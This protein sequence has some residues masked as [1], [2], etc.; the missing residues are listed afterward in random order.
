MPDRNPTAAYVSVSYIFFVIYTFLFFEG[1]HIKVSQ[2]SSKE[3]ILSMFSL[4]IFD[5]LLSFPEHST[6]Y[7]FL[8]SKS[9]KMSHCLL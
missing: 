6:T 4:S 7:L 8:K 9:G 3:N 2:E 5:K 1:C